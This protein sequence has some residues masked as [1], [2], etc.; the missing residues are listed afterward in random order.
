MRRR[1]LNGRESPPCCKGRNHEN[2][3][4]TANPSSVL[5]Q[6]GDVR[7]PGMADQGIGSPVL[8]KQLKKPYVT[9]LGSDSDVSSE[10]FDSESV[11]S[12]NDDPRFTSNSSLN[13]DGIRTV[14]RVAVDGSAVLPVRSDVAPSSPQPTS[15][16]SYGN[17]SLIKSTGVHIGN[18]TVYQ[19]PVT[20]Q[21]YVVGAVDDN[22]Q[23]KIGPLAITDGSEAG[24]VVQSSS[25][26][27][28]KRTGLELNTGSFR[29]GASAV[30][31]SKSS[32]LLWRHLLGRRPGAATLAAWIALGLGCMILVTIVLALVY[33]LGKKEASA[34]PSSDADLEMEEFSN[35]YRSP[36]KQQNRTILDRRRL[37]VV[38][39]R[40]WVAQPPKS[41]TSLRHPVEYVVLSQTATEPCTTQ[42]ECTLTVRYL[43]VFHVEGKKWMDIAYNFLVAGD[44]Q[45][46]EGRGWDVVGAHTAAGFNGISIGISF[47]GTFSDVLPPPVQM[48]ACKLLIDE[49]VRLGKI[50][51]NYKLIADRQVS[52]SENPGQK[53]YEELQTWDHWTSNV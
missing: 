19:G 21:Q 29:I 28:L 51:P 36:A 34:T 7:L 44:G 8:D 48:R 20:I 23:L 24:A 27:S 38:P 2:S 17:I 52:Q 47:V 41:T 5:E 6:V 16:T 31:A 35:G 43:Q 11:D 40:E 53:F 25:S 10:E 46:Y 33:F 15:V 49:G 1:F 39:R 13:C 12:D 45:A 37:V 9:D 18:K 42:A 50:S 3:E 30:A 22:L 32:G 26:N 14:P 4:E